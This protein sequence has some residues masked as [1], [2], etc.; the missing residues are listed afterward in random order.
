V[1]VKITVV[2]SPR[3]ELRIGGGVGMDPTAYETRARTSY[4]VAGWPTPLMDAYAELRVA[5]MMRR[6]DEQ[7]EP[8]VEVITRL[9]RKDL[10]L[11]FWRGQLEADFTYRSLEAYT[12]VGPRFR[13]GIR[14]P[15]YK[16]L[17]GLSVGWQLRV[18]D[19]S[20]IDEAIDP[21][22]AMRLGF[23]DTP[24]V[25]AFYD[26]TLFVDLRDNPAT[27][28]RGLYLA[29][30]ANEG[31]E[32]SGGEFDHVRVAPEARA[33]VNA[34][35]LVLAARGRVNALVGDDRP[36]TERVF[37]GGASSQRGFAERQ[38]S[39]TAVRVIDGVTYSA[40]IG[41][42]AAVETGVELRSPLGR[43]FSLDWGGVLFLDG[44][45]VTE[46]LGDLDLANLHWAAGAGLR[47]ATPVG[48]AR[49]D[50]GYR[51]NRTGPGEPREGEHWA[52]HLSLGE[53]F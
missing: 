28:R 30:E 26:Q 21:T 12:S 14:L 45:D 20:R 29:V 37:A 7:L 53:A 6:E 19:F 27:P 46:D 51:L 10:F 40:V 48:P 31:G 44:A 33:Y 8:R 49:F 25:L 13:A 39:P 23:D 34:G 11:P 35:K 3:H 18:L 50:V 4:G 17:I 42:G 1:P 47:I 41:G 15:I 24:Y 2:E 5:Y 9:E 52:F 16:K 22:M 43:L 36:V 38:L 32:Y